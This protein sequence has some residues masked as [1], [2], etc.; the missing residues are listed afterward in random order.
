MMNKRILYTEKLKTLVVYEIFNK[1]L[2]LKEIISEKQVYIYDVIRIILGYEKTH[3]YEFVMQFCPD[4]FL[5]E[6]E[7]SPVLA[8]PEC[9]VMISDKFIFESKYFRYPELYW[10]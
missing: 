2:Y 4:K 1:T 5:D 8:R 10:C 7:Y 3:V 6:K 9:C